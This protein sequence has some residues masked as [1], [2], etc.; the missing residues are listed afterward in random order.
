MGWTPGPIYHNWDITM[1]VGGR[2]E[3]GRAAKNSIVEEH[4]FVSTWS[5]L[6]LNKH[7]ECYSSSY[8]KNWIKG[9]SHKVC[10]RQD[11]LI[12]TTRHNYYSLTRIC[13]TSQIHVSCLA[14]T[15]V[16]GPYNICKYYFCMLLYIVLCASCW[17]GQ[18]FWCLQ[19]CRT[20]DFW[21]CII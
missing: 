12:S 2:K 20:T 13:L 1:R 5:M 6:S 18:E 7:L 16:S 10:N 21:F 4:C 3:W 17:Q 11:G 8:M 14:L 9:V 19:E 15:S